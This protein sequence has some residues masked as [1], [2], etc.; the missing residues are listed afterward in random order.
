MRYSQTGG[1]SLMYAAVS[2]AD[3]GCRGEASAVGSRGRGGPGSAGIKNGGR[4]V[5]RDSPRKRVGDQTVICL[6]M[7][8][9]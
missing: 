5:C 4:R 8:M 1:Y 7:T 6:A 2:I 9:G 3:T